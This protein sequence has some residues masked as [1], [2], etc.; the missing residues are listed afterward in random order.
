[1]E[2]LIYNVDSSHTILE[3]IIMFFLLG[4]SAS[5]LLWSVVQCVASLKASINVADSVL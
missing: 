4:C 5:V 1:M 2:F 3:L